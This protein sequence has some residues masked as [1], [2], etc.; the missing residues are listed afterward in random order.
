M[1]SFDSQDDRA[2]FVSLSVIE[3]A[4]LLGCILAYSYKFVFAITILHPA[5]PSATIASQQE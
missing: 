4:N 2:K 5:A 3:D 1:S